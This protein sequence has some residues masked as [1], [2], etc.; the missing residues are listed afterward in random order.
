MGFRPICNAYLEEMLKA[1]FEA[2]QFAQLSIKWRMT[3]RLRYVLF[4]LFASLILGS[5]SASFAQSAPMIQVLS[6]NSTTNYI[7][8]GTPVTIKWSSRGVTNVKIEY[9]TDFNVSI[10]STTRW[11]VIASSIPAANGS[12]SWNV[13]NLTSGASGRIRISDVTN[14]LVYDI[15][16]NAFTIISGTFSLKVTT[17]NGGENWT[18]GDSL[19]NITWEFGGTSLLAEFLSISLDYSTDDGNSWIPITE[20]TQGL[21]AYSKSF[22]WKIPNTPST[23]CL[24]RV[25]STDYPN[26]SSVSSAPFTISSGTSAGVNEASTSNNFYLKQNYPNPFNPTTQIQYS[27]PSAEFVSL[28][29]YNTLGQVVATLVSDIMQPGSHVARF[30]GGRFGS[31]V[32]FYRLQA[33]TSSYIKKMLLVK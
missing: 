29:V 33:G 19:H 9:T 14:P 30:D 27:I 31:G 22:T 17:P 4:F 2:I 25:R 24:V 11:T 21:I 23:K 16:D 28:K 6:L 13:P 20:G 12:Y 15:N 5:P 26:I 3:V 1:I 8:A 32:Y 18:V 10:D 7:L